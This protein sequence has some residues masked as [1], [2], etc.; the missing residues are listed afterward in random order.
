MRYPQSMMRGPAALV[1]I[2][3]PRLTPRAAVLVFLRNL[4]GPSV[5]TPQRPGSGLIDTAV[6]IVN[7]LCPLSLMHCSAR[8]AERRRPYQSVTEIGCNSIRTASPT[9]IAMP[10]IAAA[11]VSRKRHHLNL[12]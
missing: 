1:Q 12:R 11:K 3:K 4:A 7:N 8:N 10:G 9:S 2:D 5:R 6:R